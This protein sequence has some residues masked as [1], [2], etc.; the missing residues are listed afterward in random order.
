M[1]FNLHVQNDKNGQVPGNVIQVCSVRYIHTINDRYVLN[2][3]KSDRIKI[4]CSN[5]KK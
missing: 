5:T 4:L 1:L 2:S 3:V